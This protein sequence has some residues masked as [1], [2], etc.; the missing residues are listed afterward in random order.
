MPT[1]ISE[2]P[3]PVSHAAQKWLADNGF[4]QISQCQLIGSGH[5]ECYLISNDSDQRVVA[6]VASGDNDM[7]LCEAAGLETLAA[8]QAI[9]TP[10][11]HLNDKQTL[12][13]EYIS[14]TRQQSHYWE[15]LAEK[16]ALLHR[17]C[18]DMDGN[19]GAPYGLDQHNYCGASLQHN[20]WF[21]DGHEFFSEQRLL[22]QTR[23]AFDNGYLESP[24]VI[25]IESI[26]ER[27]TELVPWQ[28]S[29][30]I[31]G[32]LWP[33]NILVDELGNPALIDPAVYYGWREADIAMSLL[34]GGL[35]HE[36]Y[37]HYNDVWPMENNWRNRVP[38]YNL[39]H[40]LNHLNIFGVSYLEQ[41]HQ[42]ISR[43]A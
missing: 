31:H 9:R 11:I 4:S 7:L 6:K 29:S 32:D 39:Y 19:L 26:C 13:I 10:R 15:T 14:E 38:L 30:L 40:L 28:P 1:N 22:V 20:G 41:V 27:L 17:S 2:L 43:Y 8:S 18:P 42:T 5:H 16:I 34:F 24:W 36:F 35:P 33:G 23:L 12:L 3:F 25:S 37:H 21:E